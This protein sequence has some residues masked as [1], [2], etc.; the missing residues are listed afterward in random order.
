MKLPFILFI[1]ST[2]VVQAIPPL[3]T[4][5]LEYSIEEINKLIDSLPVLKSPRERVSELKIEE[6]PLSKKQK[7]DHVAE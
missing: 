3:A 5:L 6:R 7:L 4:E 2:A 1:V